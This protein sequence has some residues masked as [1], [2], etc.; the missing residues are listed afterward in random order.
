MSI[1]LFFVHEH[2][3]NFSY[4]RKINKNHRYLIEGWFHKKNKDEYNLKENDYISLNC[5]ICNYIYSS[6]TKISIYSTSNVHKL[7]F[8]TIGSYNYYTETGQKIVTDNT[9]SF[10]DY[11][12]IK[13]EYQGA[14]YIGNEQEIK[15]YFYCEM[16]KYKNLYNEELS[17]NEILNDNT[18]EKNE[19]INNLNSN[20][21]SLNKKIKNLNNELCEEKERT[22]FENLELKKENNK[23]KEVNE[24][25]KSFGIKY[26]TENGEGDYDI[27]LCVD[28]I[29][30]LTNK[31]WAIKY[32]KKEGKSAYEESK[33]NKTIVVGVVGNGNKGKSF[34]LKKL[35]NYDIP[36]GFN[37]KTEGL[38]I[39]YGKTGKKNLAILDSAGQETPLLIE[40]KKEK[41]T[42]ENKKDSNEDQ[43]EFEEYSRDKLIT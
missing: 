9:Y 14:I 25:L 33:H 42:E 31:G 5:C 24:N 32:N 16:I 10:Q 30:N 1:K 43:L 13:H 3:V 27:I 7:Y 34:L 20:I 40:N 15:N 18:K 6:K 22:Q 21:N 35:S 2:E 36:M 28:S 41:S 12:L 19:E 26:N 38:S 29:R 11:Y 37:V 39:I 23:L 17:K 8:N 4:C